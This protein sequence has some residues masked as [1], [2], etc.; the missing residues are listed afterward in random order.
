LG[1]NYSNVVLNLPDVEQIEEFDSAGCFVW[2]GFVKPGQHTI[3]VKGLDG[4]L[5]RRNAA[6]NLRKDSLPSLGYIDK[7]LP[8]DLRNSDDFMFQ[9]WREDTPQV[10]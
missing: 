10:C 3:I 6:V 9:S 4:Q 1:N 2:A 7:K 5:Y 8:S